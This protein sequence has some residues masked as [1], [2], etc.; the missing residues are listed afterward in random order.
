MTKKVFRFLLQKAIF[1]VVIKMQFGKA[2][3]ERSPHGQVMA[4]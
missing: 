1:F 3:D 4:V 2:C